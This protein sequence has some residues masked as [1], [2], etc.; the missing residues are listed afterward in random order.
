VSFGIEYDR[1]FSIAFCSARVAPG[2]DPFLRGVGAAS[3]PSQPERSLPATSSR[4]K[5]Q[6]A[7]AGEPLMRRRRLMRSIA[8]CDKA[9]ADMLSVPTHGCRLLNDIRVPMRD[10]VELSADVYLPR[11]DGS[12]PV[13]LI[14]TPY[15][16]IAE[17]EQGWVAEGTF[18]A[19]RGYAVVVQDVRGRFDSGGEWTPWV[20]E[21][22]DGADS[23]EWCGT[24]PWSNGSVGMIGGSYW[25]CVQ[26][27]AA[28]TPSPYL[29]TIV[30][31][32]A[33]ADIY[34]YGMNYRGG[35]FKLHGNLEWAT[36]TH[37]RTMQPSWS[38][39]ASRSDVAP[40]A[41]TTSTAA[42]Q[43][44]G[45]PFQWDELFS[46][47]PLISADEVA[48]GH[49]I[50]FYRDWI[51]HSSYDEYWRAITNF[52]RYEQIGI[53]VLQICGWFD[54]HVVSTIANLEG[55]QRAG[56]THHL[57]M[58]P[59]GHGG[60][61][62]QPFGDVDFG[63]EHAV[64][65]RTLQLRWLDR[66]LR[67]TENGVDEDPPLRLFTLGTNTWREASEWPLRE[68]R[69]TQ[70]YLRTGGRL[71][72]ANPGEA[73]QPDGYSYDPAN[74]VPTLSPNPWDDRPLDHSELESRSDVLVYTT[75]LLS[76]DLKITGPIQA[77]LYASSSAT[78]TD[79]TVRLLDVHPDGRSISICDGI[80]RARFRDPPAVRT[81]VPAPG[82]L[83]RPQLLEP[84]EIYRFT[85]EVG[86][87]SIVFQRGHRVRVHISSSNF[88]RFDRNL[89]N[90]GPTGQNTDIVVA[91]NTIHHDAERPSHLELPVIP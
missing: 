13:I 6:A 80:L 54:V 17:T 57:V 45:S 49:P 34:F 16:D 27:W 81:G 62:I 68:T 4:S 5:P 20:H 2:S 18:F 50:E 75:D 12:W 23:V 33:H 76:D 24:Q 53:P 60:P 55:L 9:A 26:W 87:T 90:G 74:P 32:S 66:W 59:W 85:I 56:A 52:G 47:L 21:I 78:D 65:F 84:D 67:G 37:G 79:W 73:E 41:G 82:Q 88:P 1:A 7:A 15:G 22:C 30:P 91:T 36:M 83:E 63:P 3:Y 25:G 11:A 31:F 28:Q 35:A 48:V 64:D 43:I 40:S 38:C 51:R 44:E 19:R 58:G 29:K 42:E 86:A 14:R 89:N 10:G 8:R 71:T 77:H 72:E 70:L 61:A 69:W 46:H 39:S